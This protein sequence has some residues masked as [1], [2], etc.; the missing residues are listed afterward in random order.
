MGEQ[1]AAGRNL[2]SVL[3]PG[4]VPQPA[5]RF[6]TFSLR[7]RPADSES[8]GAVWLAVHLD[9]VSVPF[10]TFERH[11]GC[12][13]VRSTMVTPSASLRSINDL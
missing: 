7:A 1:V 6:G 5:R 8:S 2:D 12:F 13:I 11:I 3:Y 4:E 10:K 9:P